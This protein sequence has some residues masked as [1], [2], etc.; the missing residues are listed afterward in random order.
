MKIL[1]VED[2]RYMGESLAKIL[3]AHHYTV[4]RSDDG[5]TGLELALQGSHDLIVL[6][7][8]LPTLDGISICQRLRAAG[9]TTPILILTA[10]DD[11]TRVVDGLDT[12]ADDYVVKPFD[13]E[14]LLA[15]IRALCRRGSR[16][17]PAPVLI[18]GE[19]RLDPASAI[20]TRGGEPIALRPK[21][22]SLL[23]LF[24]RN[25]RRIF[26]RDAIIDRLWTIDD[27][28]TEHA[29]TN[30]IKDLRQRLKANGIEDPIET[31]YGQGYRLKFPVSR[32]GKEEREGEIPIQTL[33]GAPRPGGELLQK[34]E[35]DFQA[36]IGE[37]ISKLQAIVRSI[38]AG[39]TAETVL[40]V[41]EAHRLAGSLGTFGYAR[42]SR[43]ARSIDRLLSES[44]EPRR[45]SGDRLESLLNELL[46]VTRAP[47]PA[48]RSSLLFIG[49][50]AADLAEALQSE[51]KERGKQLQI[52]ADPADAWRVLEQ[53]IPEAIALSIDGDREKSFQLLARLRERY[54]QIPVLVVAE[55]DSLEN[56]ARAARAGGAG[57]LA[58]P[59]TP[60]RVWSAIAALGRPATP[61]EARVLIVDDDPLSLAILKA[62]FQERSIEAI[63]LQDPGAF[64]QILTATEPD[65][66]LLDLQ[67]PDFTGIEL[68]RVTRQAPEYADLP[69]VFVSAHDDPATIAG[70]F[71]AG[72]DDFISK[73]LVSGD[74][75]TR[76]LGH[77]ERSR[78]QQGLTYSH[79]QQWR[80]WKRLA[81]LD[82]LTRVAN[83]RAFDETL[84]AEWRDCL[85][86]RRFLSLLLCDIDHFKDYNDRYGHPAG[87]VCL[88]KIAAALQ[89][90]LTSATDI[91]ARYGGEEFA[92]IL[93]NTSLGGA[94]AVADRARQAIADLAI[95]HDLAPDIQKVTISIGIAGFVPAEND[96]P[97]HLVE[98]AD[99]ALYTAKNRGRNTYC[100]YCR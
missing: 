49:A 63:D 51:A 19:L 70:V 58:R 60:A 65:L 89:D 94:L 37:R 14:Q 41:R 26:T 67:M 38:L 87:D 78:L 50:N 29:V 71:A 69:I 6:D 3:T 25:P 7:I 88:Q 52:A 40:A 81:Y 18:W 2:D 33:D 9:K 42:G 75:V 17:L 11:N 28:P 99:Q 62:L 72:A 90:C 13:P 47:D 86:S 61:T 82:P 97:D 80:K 5:K 48:N 64:W 4:E 44:E 92:V 10:L 43:V 12:G 59:F 16:P 74:I 84:R 31:V 54:G 21:E 76:V 45:I 73:P 83:R 98:T 93:P 30:L 100:L 32:D 22:Y 15:R 1:L 53:T 55:E 96:S 85:L 68:C 34:I 66:V 57:Y 35:K 24:L 36:S 8:Q 39:E 79:R 95:P 27:C 23:E 77:L 91:V 56:R 46:D 20:V